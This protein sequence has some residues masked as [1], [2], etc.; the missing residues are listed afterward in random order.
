MRGRQVVEVLAVE[1]DAQQR[2]RVAVD[3]LP[4]AASSGRDSVAWSR[5]NASMTSTADGPV[6]EDDRRGAE[7]IEQVVELDRQHGFWRPAAAPG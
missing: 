7:R 5:M 4:Q 6:P 2:E 1:L 3:D